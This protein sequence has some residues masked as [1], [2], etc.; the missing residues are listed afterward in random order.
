METI[1]WIQRLGN[2]G[3][4]CTL[5]CILIGFAL[6]VLSIPTITCYCNT[7]DYNDSDCDYVMYK[8]LK[9]LM[10]KFS[11]SFFITMFAG[12]F[13][14]SEKDL[15]AIYGIGGTIDYI[16]SNETAKGLPDKAVKALDLWLDEKC[17][18]KN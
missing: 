12:I 17:K 5:F 18:E 13:I 6:I 16:R 1:Y 8:K 14:P 4:L 7:E 15:Y 3:E 11:I 10:I 9:S 2:I